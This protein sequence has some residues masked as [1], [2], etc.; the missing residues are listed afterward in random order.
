MCKLQQITRQPNI[1]AGLFSGTE[2]FWHEGEKWVLTN[3]TRKPFHECDS[4]IQ[5]P[6]WKAF[7]ADK[8]SLAYIA[9]MGISKASEVFDTWYRCV[10]GGLDH[11]PD[12][13]NEKF[14][15][16]AFN[17]LCCD[18]SCPHRGRLCSRATGLKNYEVETIAALKQGE[19]LEQ[20]ASH[21]FVSLPGMKSRVEKIK[22][23]LN[24]SNMAQ[25]MARTAELGI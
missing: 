7:M 20:T 10:V 25:L 1:P 15:P 22:I 9:K 24:V 11:V 23:K 2:A 5:Q 12:F 13:L 6:I 16:D 4:S 3:G 21:I 14:T 19:S 17:N 8:H 18:F